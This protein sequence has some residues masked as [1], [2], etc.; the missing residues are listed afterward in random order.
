[1]FTC[2]TAISI[3]LNLVKEDSSKNFTNSIKKFIA[4][5]GCP[6]KI[7]SDNGTVFKSQESQLICFEQGIT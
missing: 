5:R 3:I 2:A 7:I 1:M 4:R 6:K